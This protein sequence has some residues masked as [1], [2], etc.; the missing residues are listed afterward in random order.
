MLADHVAVAEHTKKPTSIPGFNVMIDAEIAIK[1]G[2]MLFAKLAP[3][4]LNLEKTIEIV[5]AEKCAAFV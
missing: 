1:L 2:L 3:T 5:Y 4:S